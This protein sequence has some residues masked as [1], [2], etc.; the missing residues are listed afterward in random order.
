MG[1]AVEADDTKTPPVKAVKAVAAVA[2]KCEKTKAVVCP[3]GYKLKAAATT[4]AT[5]AKA[6]TRRLDETKKEDA[7]KE[8]AKAKVEVPKECEAE[9]TTPLAGATTLA[10]SSVIVSLL[11]FFYF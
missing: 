3:K 10:T 11:A 1:E 4:K 7:K 2:A 5:T 8:D 6:K 9:A